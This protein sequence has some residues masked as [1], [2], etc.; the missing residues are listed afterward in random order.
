MR[1]AY[2]CRLVNAEGND[3][4]EQTVANPAHWAV[5]LYEDTA[6]CDVGTGELVDG[7]DVDWAEDQPEAT[8]AE[9]LRHANTVTETTVFA[10]E[11]FCLDYRAAGLTADM[12]FARNARMVDIDTDPASVDVD[13]D[14]R[15]AARQK[16]QAERAEAEKRERREVLA[17]NKLGDAAMG[18]RREFVKKL[19]A[20]KT[21][22]K[23]AA[24]FVANCLTRNSYLLTNNNA[25]DT[26]AELLGVDSAQAVAKLAGELRG[27]DDRAQVITLALVLGATTARFQQSVQ[28]SW[29]TPNPSRWTARNCAPFIPTSK[30]RPT[31]E[32]RTRTWSIGQ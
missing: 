22:P 26:T 12:W 21:P 29:S 18:V 19:L 24:I 5:L 17:L 10:P 31:S 27:G 8:P 13:D 30:R 23:G 2:R 14:A 6:L 7:D 11:Y 32:N 15:E 4:D 3:A 9:G 25:L 28:P 16:A 1:P 20:R